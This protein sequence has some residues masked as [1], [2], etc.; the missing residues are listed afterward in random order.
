METEE[1]H[2]VPRALLSAQ[3]TIH[4]HGQTTITAALLL[5]GEPGHIFPFKQGRK[6]SLASETATV[7]TTSITVTTTTPTPCCDNAALTISTTRM[8]RMTIWTVDC[9]YEPS[10]TDLEPESRRGCATYVDLK[11]GPSGLGDL[12]LPTMG[13]GRSE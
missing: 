2:S 7:T 4:Y 5:A 3:E 11:L 9:H 13:H 10:F 12:S 8:L 6:H 1:Q